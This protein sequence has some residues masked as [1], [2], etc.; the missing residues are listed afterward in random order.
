M[1]LSKIFVN[2]TQIIGV[3]EEPTDGSNDFV[4]SDGVSNAIKNSKNE[5]ITNA[6]DS[7]D[8]SKITIRDKCY[9]NRTKLVQK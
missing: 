1:S 3:D 2:N 4:K 6:S 8:I 9:F 5:I 7:F